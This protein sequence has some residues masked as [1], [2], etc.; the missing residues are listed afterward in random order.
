MRKFKIK[1]NGNAYEVEVEEIG[2]SAAPVMA[3]PI[4]APAAP[5]AASSDASAPAGS[6]EVSAPMP[7]QHP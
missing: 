3:A 7:R 6:T 2:G 4:T 5:A 1:V